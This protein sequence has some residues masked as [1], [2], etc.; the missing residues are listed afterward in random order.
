MLVFFVLAGSG[1]WVSAQDT[2]PP[3]VV[4]STPA[5]GAVNVS[6]NLNSFSI[7]FSE[8][9]SGSFSFSWDDGIWAPGPFAWS[10]GNTVLTFTRNSSDPLPGGVTVSFSIFNLR[11]LAGNY[12][13]PNPLRISFLVGTSVDNPPSITSAIPANGA[14]GVSRDLPSVSFTFSEPMNTSALNVY[15]N[16]PSF[17]ASWSDYHRVLTFTRNDLQTRLSPGATYSITINPAGGNTMTDTQGNALPPTTFTFTTVEEYD[18]GF[19]KIPAN[20]AKGFYWP[21]YLCVPF[22]LSPRTVLLVEPN[23]TGTTSDDLALHDASAKNL[24]LW[25]STFAI[26]HDLPLL[27]PTFPRPDNPGWVYTHALDRYSLTTTAVVGGYSIERIDRQ[28]IA[29]INDAR[30]RLTAMGHAV[31]KRVF[32]HGFSASGAFTSRFSLLH[33]EMIKAAAP[34]SPGG[35]PIAPVSSWNIPSYGTTTLRYPVG[36]ADV[37]T[38]SGKP[39][40]L[41]AFRQAPFYIYV[42]DI[43]NN[44]ALDTREFPQNE[45]NAICSWLDCDPLPWIAD[46]WPISE[47]IYDSVNAD[48]QFVNYPRVAHTITEE[49]FTDIGNFFEQHRTPV[50]TH[51][52]Q[53]HWDYNGDGATDIAALHSLSDQFFTSA[54]GNL[55]QYGWG[56]NDAFPLVWDSD[57]D[58]KTDVSIYH[59]PSN[60]WFVRGYPG[61]NLGQYGFGGNQS[62]PVPG[63]YDGDGAMDRA[64]YHWPTNR[65]FIEGRP[66][67]VSFGWGGADCIPIAGDYDGDG[68]TDLLLYHVPSNQWFVHGVGNLGQFGWGG[69]ECLPVPGDWNGDGK[70]EIAVYHVPSNQWFW[71][72]S[73]GGAHFT[74]QYG[75][76]EFDSFPIPGDYNGDGAL[77]RAFYRPAEN[78]WFIDGRSEFVWGWGGQDFMPVTSQISVYNWFRFVLGRFE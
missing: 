65:W 31:D 22:T 43:D 42:G 16:F 41:D 46:R 51:S 5:S 37:E 78:R 36:M 58:G 10:A 32:M 61:D 19:Y 73:S 60:Q 15:S 14:T 49:M 53:G 72:D 1:D 18:F 38:L 68:V 48:G 47:T 66:D 74:G 76:G 59:I 27:V 25:R 8:A 30:E 28:L 34:G 45:V 2:T 67:P 55:G 6:V 57:G 9:M 24:L 64:F 71:R 20:P 17:S 23:N 39:F 63:D 12:L 70:M 56:G 33:P 52:Q 77:E 40:N 13:S 29:M 3:A 54:D 21:Y 50:V 35:W 69:P 7:F 75:W 44:D 26:A 62:I 11:D 4:S